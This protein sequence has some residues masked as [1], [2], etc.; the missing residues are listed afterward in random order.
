MSLTRG[1]GGKLPCLICLVPEKKL[2]HVSRTWPLRTA[3]HTQQLLNEARALNKTGCESLLSQYGLRN[4][5]VSFLDYF[6]D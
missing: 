1:Y 3:V 4:I 6:T 2:V 5:D